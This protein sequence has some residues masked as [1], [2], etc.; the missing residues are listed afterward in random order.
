MFRYDT[1]EHPPV[2]LVTVTVTDRITGNQ[3]VLPGKL[4]TGAAI[5]VLP[6]TTVAALGLTPQSDVWVA[7]YDAQ[8]IQ[9]P[10][11]F[12]TLEVAG[13]MIEMVKVTASPRSQMLLGRDVLSHFIA[14][15]DG[16][17]L[18]FD[19]DTPHPAPAAR[20]ATPPPRSGHHPP[21][22]CDPRRARC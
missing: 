20:R 15:F 13:C 11:Y 5:S 19:P 14:T 3:A 10:A 12:V 2:A 7:G 4:D 21:R 9:L 18:T 16:K 22:K 6:V 1:N 17:N 8:F